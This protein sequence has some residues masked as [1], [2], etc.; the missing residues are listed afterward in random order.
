MLH[1]DISNSPKEVFKVK[2]VIIELVENNKSIIRIPNI[3][4][5]IKNIVK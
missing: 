5:K 4:I 1:F 2:E 3:K